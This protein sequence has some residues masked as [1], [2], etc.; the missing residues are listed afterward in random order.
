MLAW[1]SFLVY[2]EHNGDII[3][4][5]WWLIDFQRWKISFPT[6]RLVMLFRELFFREVVRLHGLPRSLVSDRDTKFV[7]YFWQ[8]LWKKLKIE[9]K[10]SSS[11]H[12]Q[13]NGQIE[14]VNCG[15]GN[16]LRCFIGDKPKCQYMILPQVEFEYNNSI[17]MSTSKSPFQIVYGN[18]ARNAS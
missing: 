10:F 2:Q 5:L 13:T 17:N 4:Y 6:R 15:L 14:V 7:V 16:L 11:H 3:L 1:I 18:S 12:P 9:L 8:T